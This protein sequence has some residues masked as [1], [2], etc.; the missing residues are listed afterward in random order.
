MT[1]QSHYMTLAISIMDGYDLSNKVHHKCLPKQIGDTILVVE[2][3]AVST[4]K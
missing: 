1:F 4:T 2:F 3:I